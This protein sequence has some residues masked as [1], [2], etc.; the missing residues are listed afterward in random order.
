EALRKPGSEVLI[1]SDSKYLIDCCSKWLPGW[2]RAGWKR[3]TGPL[4]N[5]DLLQRLDQ[6]LDSHQVR[7]QWVRGHS[8]NPGNE[9]VD[10]LANQI[11]DR[12]QAGAGT[13]TIDARR[14]W[15]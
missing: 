8:G 12:L 6:L 3:R 4:K 13:T 2:K 14:M 15:P 9:R 1:H 10:A 11:M 7:W 5:I